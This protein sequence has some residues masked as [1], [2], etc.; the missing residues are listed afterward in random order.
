MR[1]GLRQL[2]SSLH[3]HPT[4]QACA[5]LAARTSGCAWSA[6]KTMTAPMR[7]RHQILNSECATVRCLPVCMPPVT[8]LLLSCLQ[9]QVWVLLQQCGLHH[10]HLL[11]GQRQE[12]VQD[13]QHGLRG[14]CSAV[15]AGQ[16]L[17]RPPQPPSWNKICTKMSEGQI[18]VPRW[19]NHCIASSLLQ[20]CT[21]NL[22]VRCPA[23]QCCDNGQTGCAYEADNPGCGRCCPPSINC[24]ADGSLNT[25]NGR[26]CGASSNDCAKEDPFFA[27]V[28]NYTAATQVD[29][30]KCS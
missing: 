4:L 7:C 2:T 3:V 11:P 5:A 29:Y 13:T 17:P 21:G 19:P 22:G 12:R 20:A 15:L 14:A 24:K 6:A 26:V 28:L 1:T 8:L 9:V 25:V 10:L 23:G 30:S 18:R 16:R 27:T